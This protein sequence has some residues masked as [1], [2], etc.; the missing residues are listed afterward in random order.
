MLYPSAAQSVSR[1]QI[2]Q[3]RRCAADYA[4]KVWRDHVSDMRDEM[5]GLL[6]IHALG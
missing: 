1:M 6:Q 3:V 5:R 4:L 2:R